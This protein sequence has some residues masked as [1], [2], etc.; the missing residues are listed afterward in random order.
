MFFLHFNICISKV[1]VVKRKWNLRQN[2][3]EEISLFVWFIINAFHWNSEIESYYCTVWNIIDTISSA[4]IECSKQNSRL[5]GSYLSV[6]ISLSLFIKYRYMYVCTYILKGIKTSTFL[7]MIIILDTYR[8]TNIHWH[9]HIVNL[10][11]ILKLGMI[12]ILNIICS[13]SILSLNIIW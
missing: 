9:T 1:I 13:H 2:C 8:K 7:F 5:T 10:S 11:S 12:T 3:W 6:P 4:T